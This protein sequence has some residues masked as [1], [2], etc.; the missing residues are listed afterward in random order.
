MAADD[1]AA[2]DRA[3]GLPGVRAASGL[4]VRNETARKVVINGDGV[5][6]VLAPFAETELSSED[7]K[8]FNEDALCHSAYVD[9]FEPAP[10]KPRAIE[11]NPW[12]AL[13]GFLVLGVP[14]WAIVGAFVGSPGYWRTGVLVIA[15]VIAVAVAGSLIRMQQ[16]KSPGSITS[17]LSG[18]RDRVTQQ[19]Y[20]SA[21][22]AIGVLVP[23]AVI[24]FSAEL[25]DVVDTMRSAEPGTDLHPHVLTLIGRGIQL[26]FIAVVSLLPALLFFLFDRE[27]LA[28]LRDRFMRQIVR[29]D[30]T[31]ETRSDIRAKY[32]RAMDEAYGHE[33]VGKGRLLPGRRSPVLVATVIITLGWIL[34]LAHADSELIRTGDG[35]LAL[36]EPPR[37]PV[38]YAFL[39]AYVYALGVVLRGYVR[40]D[41]RPKSYSHITVR[42]ILVIVLAWVLQLQWSGDALLLVVF[43]AGLVPET[44]IVLIKEALRGVTALPFPFLEEE[45]DPLTRLEGIDVY[46]RA[47]LLDEGVASVEGLAHHDVV[48][49]MLQTRIHASQLVD[50]VDQAILYLHA[51]PRDATDGT[52]RSTTLGTLRAYGI[53][54]A[55]DLVKAV[56]EAAKR[57]GDDK[58]DAV[59]AKKPGSGG[60][61][62]R[63]QVI[64]DVIR[65][66]EWMP[67][68]SRWHS[69]EAVEPAPFEIDATTTARPALRPETLKAPA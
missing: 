55:T 68:L 15:A 48:E 42:T 49:L 33:R 6:I 16:R 37:E 20:L 17:W 2:P 13:L 65:D 56:D 47:R 9:A 10:A 19:M 11:D 7:R 29:F 34:T 63:I 50:W 28:T 66:E 44:A 54:T 23:A 64:Y 26:V 67:N 21:N 14:I 52:G 60:G 36:L 31:V 38:V 43:V 46:D 58:L 62:S 45:P 69:D 4:V 40:K 12:M 39:G 59:L 27:Q 57:Q 8:R 25:L 24:V 30:S 1:Q 41:L 61:P 32:G 35:L 53:R 22:V 3:N 18:A 51:G 5:E